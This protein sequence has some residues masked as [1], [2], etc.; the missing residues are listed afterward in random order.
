MLA[1]VRRPGQPPVLLW[2]AGL[3]VW[4]PGAT[5]SLHAH[6]AVQ[7]ILTL[8]GHGR[9]RGRARQRWTDFTAALIGPD[10]PHEV[11]ARGT[12]V[13]IAFVDPESE[14]GA[15]LLGRLRAPV[16][17]LP[18]A[19]VE[20]WRRELGARPLGAAAVEA[21]W[22]ARIAAGRGPRRIHPRVSRVLRWLRSNVA[23]SADDCSLQA[24]AERAGLS[25]SRFM[26]VFTQSVGVP[27][28]PYLLWLRL[29]HAAGRVLSGA[30][31]T[32][33]AHEAGF[34]DAAHLSRTFR[35]T[36]GTTPREIA[37]GRAQGQLDL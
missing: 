36:L 9:V 34:A 24:L 21:W 20:R 4:G 17:V 33:A 6:H 18:A 23:A 2:P 3:V 37:A 13:V 19:E 16:V 25:P 26:H 12:A 10:V 30:T 32:E 8:D 29:Q 28:R 14:V 11:D 22:R 5:S 7:L 27:V 35:R 1:G 31:A 15:G